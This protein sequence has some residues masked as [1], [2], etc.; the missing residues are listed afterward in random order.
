[1]FVS[2]VWPCCASERCVLNAL[3]LGDVGPAC[4]RR[5][6]GTRILQ[7]RTN[8]LFVSV[9][10]GLLLLAPVSSCECFDEFER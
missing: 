4:Y 9:S 5:P 3:K 7:H 6:H 1:M 2:R 8:T 10:E